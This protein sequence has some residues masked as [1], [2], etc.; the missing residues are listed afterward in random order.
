MR[1]LGLFE[2]RIDPQIV[3]RNDRHQRRGGAN[4]RPWLYGTTGNVAGHR[5]DDFGTLQGKPCV[6]HFGR[7][8]FHRWLVF[9]RGTQHHRLISVVLLDRHVQL[10]LCAGH[11]VAGV[12]QLFTANQVGGAER[13][14][15]I[16][17]ALRLS[18]AVFCTSILA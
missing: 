2:V 6:T 9:Q 16:E 18:Q 4:L 12:L 17:V 1:Q 10:R 3:C 8:L 7:R 13:N 15:T 11:R 14:T 5:A